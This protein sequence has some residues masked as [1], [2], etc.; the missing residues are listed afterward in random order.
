M[1]KTG[2]GPALELLAGVEPEDLA[3]LARRHGLA[4]LLFS[5]LKKAEPTPAIE[6][7]MESSRNAL[8]QSMVFDLL[9][10]RDACALS[11]DLQGA[12]ID[13]LVLKGPTL[14]R[15][16]G[17]GQRE[18]SDLDLL[19]R[20]SDLLLARRLLIDQG[21]RQISGP[22]EH[23]LDRHLAVGKEIGLAAPGRIPID[24]HWRFGE[25]AYPFDLPD[26]N[27][28]SRSQTTDLKAA[29]VQT[30]GNEELLLY[31]RFHGTR[32]SV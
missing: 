29:Q 15:L 12:G 24:L 6:G 11:A 3:A 20:P 16:Y 7:L 25:R 27:L 23:L 21:Y 28:W 10:A 4:P 9:A 18:Y 14:T 26:N 30:L 31:L 32:S 1:S 19:V 8:R 5:L 17:P 22:P 13:V 2:Y